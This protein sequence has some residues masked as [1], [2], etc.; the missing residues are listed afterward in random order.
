MPIFKFRSIQLFFLPSLITCTAVEDE[1]VLQ[2]NE[3]KHKSLTEKEIFDHI[4]EKAKSFP[5]L[6]APNIAYSPSTETLNLIRKH[7]RENELDFPSDDIEI[8]G[9]IDRII[10]ARFTSVKPTTEPGGAEQCGHNTEKPQHHGTPKSSSN[11]NCMEQI[12]P[13]FFQDDT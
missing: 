5:D 8:L 13:F 11:F 1:P 12:G 4:R 6:T 9:E 3:D 7:T 2:V 10:S